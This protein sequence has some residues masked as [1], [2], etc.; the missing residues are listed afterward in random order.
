MSRNLRHN[1]GLKE[2]D[3]AHL[4][5]LMNDFI[6]YA[7]RHERAAHSFP[8]QA[9]APSTGIVRDG[10]ALP[11]SVRRRR[12]C[13]ATTV[14]RRDQEGRL[15]IAEYAASTVPWYVSVPRPEVSGSSAC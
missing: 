1:L 9:R 15:S 7:V 12:R 14:Q 8:N 11:S 2:A 6:E 10:S 3:T 13:A 4:E 5:L